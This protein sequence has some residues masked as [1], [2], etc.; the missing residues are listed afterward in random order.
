VLSIVTAA[1]DTVWRAAA[2]WVKTYY[3]ADRTAVE[4]L[5]ELRQIA[6]DLLCR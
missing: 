5:S 1:A 4:V 2:D 3:E 6:G